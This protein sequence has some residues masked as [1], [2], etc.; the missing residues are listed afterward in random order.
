MLKDHLKIQSAKEHLYAVHDFSKST[1]EINAHIPGS[2]SL[3]SFSKAN[4]ES[5]NLT[6]R[7]IIISC[8]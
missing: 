6:N 1:T 3:H 4:T 8:N 5:K 7:T 2:N